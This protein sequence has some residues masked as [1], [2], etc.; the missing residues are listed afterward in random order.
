ML[1]TSV[2]NQI[3]RMN[4]DEG[5]LLEIATQIMILDAGLQIFRPKTMLTIAMI[6]SSRISSEMKKIQEEAES[7]GLAI[8]DINETN[9]RTRSCT[10]KLQCQTMLN[11]REPVSGFLKSPNRIFPGA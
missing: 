6:G 5:K 4:M 1:G 11:I 3:L 7:L 10:R 8:A 9:I 2:D